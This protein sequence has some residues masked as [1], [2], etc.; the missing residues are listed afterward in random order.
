MNSRFRS[1][2]ATLSLA[3]ISLALSACAS[4]PSSVP[5]PTARCPKPAP[6]PATILQIDTRPSTPSLSKASEWSERSEAI[7]TGETPK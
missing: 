2:C 5:P 6:L 3:L 1:R 7:L 4:V